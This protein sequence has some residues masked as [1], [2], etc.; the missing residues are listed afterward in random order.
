MV[1]E[2]LN[3]VQDLAGVIVKCHVR[4]ILVIVQVV[5]TRHPLLWSQDNPITFPSRCKQNKIAANS[6]CIYQKQKVSLAAS[7]NSGGQRPQCQSIE[8]KVL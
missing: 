6:K 1:E 8:T 7:C 5:V 4:L 2:S 3:C